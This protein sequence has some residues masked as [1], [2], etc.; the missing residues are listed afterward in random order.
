MELRI[1]NKSIRYLIS[2]VFGIQLLRFVENVDNFLILL[3]V[4]TALILFLTLSLTTFSLILEG[5]C[6]IF[7]NIYT[8][9]RDSTMLQH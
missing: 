2:N 5:P 1:F 7:C 8:F 9:Q 3:V 4:F 6:I